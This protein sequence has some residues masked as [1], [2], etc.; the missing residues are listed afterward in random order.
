MKNPIASLLATA[1]VCLVAT[2]SVHA[3]EGMAPLPGSA[4]S[5]AATEGLGASGSATPAV[6]ASQLAANK[7]AVLAF[8]EAGLNRK[9][10]AAARQFLGDKYIQHNPNAPDGV[11]GFGKFVDF[12]RKNQPD[13]HSDIVRAFADGD[14]VILH[15]R[16]VPHPGDLP[17]AIVD[18]FRLEKGKIVEHWD[19]SQQTPAKTVSGNSMF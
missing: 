14:F 10:F 1:A 4:I 13:S 6:P 18:I 17:I 5:A 15:V 2:A 19:V 9:D 16:K 8:Y 11:E 7:Q 3:A 12:L